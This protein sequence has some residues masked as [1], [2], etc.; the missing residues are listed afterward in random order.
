MTNLDTITETTFKNRIFHLDL[1]VQ[2]MT[3]SALKALAKQLKTAGYTAVVM[4]WEATF[5][6]KKHQTLASKYV[7]S[8]KE[9][10][11]VLNY[12]KKIGL[13]TIPLQ[14]CF[15]HVEYILQHERYAHLKEDERDI[16]QV[17][18]LKT[19]EALALFKELFA[20]LIEAHNS[21]YFYVGCDETY[22]LGKCPNCAKKAKEHGKSKLYV[23]YLKEI[24]NLV[25][26]FGKRPLCPADE[27]LKHPE[28][29]SLLPKD[30]ILVDWNYG[31]P[32]GKFGPPEPLLKMGFE[33]WGSMSLRSGPDN[34]YLHSWEKHLNNYRDFIP[35][36][37]K[38]GYTGVALTSWSTSGIYGSEW[39]AFYEVVTL[40]PIRR[41][42]PLN[43]FNLLFY[44][45]ANSMNSIAPFEPKKYVIEFVGKQYGLNNLDSIRF[46]NALYVSASPVYKPKIEL[47]T[48]P[49]KLTTLLANACKTLRSLQPQK[50]KKE[51]EHYRLMADIRW[52]YLKTKQLEEEI[53]L[54]TFSDKIRLKILSPL[55][56]LLKNESAFAIRFSKLMKGYLQPGEIRTENEWRKRK[57]S[58]LIEKLGRKRN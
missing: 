38:M 18:P 21:P 49:K 8:R 50:N 54:E 46:F 44:A 51:F 17:C 39:D 27:L 42:Y 57:L 12:C 10:L 41:V 45:F 47:Y 30:T 15:G 20:E 26:S 55:K 28:S 53:Q 23:D 4:E 58:L 33:F 14:Q 43:G 36:C 13:E 31:W 37:K 2:V 56:K 7:Y 35:Y 11:S 6:F 19:K 25:K 3:T 40:H 24:L 32:V 9:I 1:R 48:N 52:N 16:C 34:Y 22:I 29:A 5:P